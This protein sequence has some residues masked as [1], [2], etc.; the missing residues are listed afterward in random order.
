MAAR[1]EA[2]RGCERQDALCPRRGVWSAILA[3][4][5]VTKPL[6]KRA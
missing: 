4:T 5:K 2:V 6:D 1:S 3:V